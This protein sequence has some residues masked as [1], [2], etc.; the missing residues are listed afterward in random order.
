MKRLESVLYPDWPAPEHVRAYST[1]RECG[2]STGTFA[3]MNLALHV[4]DEPDRVVRNRATLKQVL[5]LPSEPA[6]L[7]QVHGTDVHTVDLN[8]SAKGSPVCADASM[9][10]GVGG[11]CAVMTADC[12]PVLFCDRQGTCVAAAHAGW[13]G[14]AGGVLESTIEAMSIPPSELLVWLGPAIGV[15]HFEVGSEVRE[16]FVNHD[17]AA[18]AAFRPS[19][20]GLDQG[21]WLADMV[22]LAKQRL[23]AAG[24]HAVYGGKWCTYSDSRRFYSYRR[25][26]QTGRMASLIYLN[27]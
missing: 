23:A 9:T 7:E 24:V 22:K 27:R 10:R 8:L 1:T 2:A 4:G 26:V 17:A 12:L 11:V 20:H 25:E 5:G 6:W 18:V 15:G 3:A 14:L 16:A 13:R 21:R 19:P